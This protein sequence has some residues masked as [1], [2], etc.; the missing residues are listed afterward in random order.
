MR[1]AANV[2]SLMLLLAVVALIMPAVFELVQGTGLPRPQAEAVNSDVERLSVGVAAARDA[3]AGTRGQRQA[4]RARRPWPTD[5][6]GGRRVRAI[7]DKG[8]LALPEQSARTAQEATSGGRAT[9]RINRDGGRRPVGPPLIRAF[10]DAH[11]ELDISLHIGNRSEVFSALLDQQADDA[12]GP[13]RVEA[14]RWPR[15]LVGA[16][17]TDRR[18]GAVVRS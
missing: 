2:T 6:H 14:V 3:Y 15:R 7:R 13:P 16:G 4:A 10:R 9:L 17:R 12:P 8:L 1:T 18:S 5:D 11:P